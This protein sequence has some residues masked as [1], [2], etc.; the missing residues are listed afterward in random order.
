MSSRRRQGR[1]KKLTPEDR[2]ARRE[3][4]KRRGRPAYT[5]ANINGIRMR[6]PK[7]DKEAVDA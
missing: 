2:Q 1:M 4:N 7:L 6:V 5:F 3:R